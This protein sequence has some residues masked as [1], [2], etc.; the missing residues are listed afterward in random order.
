[1]YKKVKIFTDGSCLKNP[2]PGGYGIILY[3][4]KYKKLLS[5]GFY[6]TTN[7]RMELIAVIVALELLKQPCIVQ[8]NTD[9]K[10]VQL[11]IKYWI[12]NWKKSRW[13]TYNKHPVKNIDLWQRLYKK[14]SYHEIE[15]NWIK[16]HSGNTDNEL[17]DEL[18]RKA[19]KSPTVND[20]KYV[21]F[22][23]KKNKG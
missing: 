22:C 6:L 12:H 18:A 3:Y 10:Y 17:C 9:S 14:L 2:G 23:D 13:L 1:M 15:W 11:G 19:A 8:I 7:N 5:T 4:E 21:M 20:T 16:A